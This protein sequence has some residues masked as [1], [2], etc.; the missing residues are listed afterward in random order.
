MAEENDSPELH[1]ARLFR[2]ASHEVSQAVGAE[3]G[4]VDWFAT[5]REG[6]VRPRTYWRAWKTCPEGLDDALAELE[7]ARVARHA[8]RALGVVMEGRLPEGYTAES[9]ATTRIVSYRRF[10]LEVSGISARIADHAAKYAAQ[11]EP[12]RHLPQP[13]NAVL[14]LREWVQRGDT[15]LLLWGTRVSERIALVNHVAYEV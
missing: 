1:V 12:A 6:F 14:V 5:P 15:D 4:T 9:G 8:D 11:G 2:L 3:P 7:E 13:E 10:A